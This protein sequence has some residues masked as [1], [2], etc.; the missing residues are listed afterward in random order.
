[1]KRRIRI[2]ILVC[3]AVSVAMVLIQCYFLYN[4]WLLYQKQSLSEI[5][6]QLS[7]TESKMQLDSLRSELVN[8]I[9]ADVS[10]LGISEMSKH[11]FDFSDP[12]SSEKIS[13]LIHSNGLLKLHHVTYGIRIKEAVIRYSSEHAT[14]ISRR[15]QFWFGNTGSLVNQFPLSQYTLTRTL[16]DPAGKPVFC[17]LETESYFDVENWKTPLMGKLFGLI[18]FSCALVLGVIALFYTA[19]RN[20]IKQ[21][22]IA[23]LKTDFVNNITHEFNTPLATLNIAIATLTRLK[24]DPDPQASQA[25]ST[26]ERQGRRLQSL[27]KQA[28][29]FSKPGAEI[30]IKKTQVNSREFIE[31]LIADF[32][33]GHE[34]VEINL[35]QNQDVIFYTDTAMLT[36]AIQAILDNAA[37]YGGTEL[38]IRTRADETY[39][40]I[41]LTDNGKGMPQAKLKMIFEKFYRIRSG[42]T[43]DTK[44]LGLGLYY[45]RQIIEAHQGRIEVKSSPGEGATFHVLIPLR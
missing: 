19:I 33:H 29:E 18:L 1:V 43:H 13:T 16:K 4:T 10:T 37:K 26:I 15:N 7:L 24:Q 28:V 31:N 5:K 11:I 34:A 38:H 9:E 14:P 32:S 27:V 20:I 45:A 12:V 44:G 35:E 23:D 22:R 17:E 40:S 42:N 6:D 2:L 39:F 30:G 25:L 8:Q 21:K 41:S 3:I 36:T